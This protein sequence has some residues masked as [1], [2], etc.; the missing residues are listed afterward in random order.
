MPLVT[1]SSNSSSAEAAASDSSR[2]IWLLAIGGVFV[3]ALVLRV[4]YLHEIRAIGFFDVLL[5]DALVYDQRAQEIVA[6]DWLGPADFIHAPLYPFMLAAVRAV[7]F[8]SLL[9]PRL[10]QAM[11]GAWSCVLLMA[12]VRRAAR[13][14]WPG[15]RG[16]TTAIVAGALLAVY[17]PAI[18]FDGLV[19]KASMV[20]FLSTL[21]L[22]LVFVA[23]QE[24]RHHWWLACGLSLGLLVIVRQNALAVAPLLAVAAWTGGQHENP[25]PI[26]SQRVVSLLALMIGLMLVLS[27]WIVRH[28][29]VLDEWFLSTPNLGQNFAMGNH[30]EGTG[31]YLPAQRGRAAGEAEQAVW[32]QA[33][34]RELGRPLSA[35]EVSDY[36]L[37]ASLDYIAAEPG[38]WLRLTGKKLL[39]VF[40]AYEL[41]DTED[42]YLYKEH[43]A[44]LRVGDAVLHFGVIGP[45]AVA[46]MIITGRFWRRWW[47]LY[48]WLAVNALAIAAFVVFARYRLPILPVVLLLAAIGIVQGFGMVRSGQWRALLW[49]VCGLVIAA[50]IMNWPVHSPRRTHAFSYVNHAVALAEAQRYDEALHELDKAEALQPGD[51]DAHWIRA[52]VHFDL[53]NFDEALEHYQLAL[54]GDP[55]FGGAHRGIGAV[56]VAV[57]K[58]VQAEQHFQAALEL[59]PLDH[60]AMSKL[61]IIYT[62]RS[63]PLRALALL[64]KAAE[65]APTDAQVQLNMGNVHLALRQFDAAIAAYE[66][67]LALDPQY[68]DAHLNL[69]SVHAANGDFDSAIVHL[70]LALELQPDN[71]QAILTLVNLYV[72]SD[73]RVEA[74]EFL[75]RRIAAGDAHYQPLLNALMQP[76]P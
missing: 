54:A 68:V 47:L 44:I 5:S 76:G 8:E 50:A 48:G 30:P 74:V 58:Y 52:G 66:H 63:E 10:V 59:D 60:I 49:P 22:W 29:I 56:L 26:G 24:R 11:L 72:Q 70:R 55:T 43:S 35:A 41:P 2:P 33:A 34:E 61:A 67:A 37:D 69:A 28:K 38:A 73:Q 3:L 65:I 31:T 17:P 75:K 42:Y 53:Q 32:Q 45:L 20:L 27:P 12:L 39:M 21:V 51:V 25:K 15:N 18:F 71:N 1:G 19:Q 62:T 64:E 9:A 23:W 13:Q 57:G 46:G 40:G 6:G 14:C 4:G 16:Q 7:G 36:Y